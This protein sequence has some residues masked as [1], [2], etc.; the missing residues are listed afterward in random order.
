MFPICSTH[1]HIKKLTQAI[2]QP[3]IHKVIKK[4]WIHKVV[5]FVCFYSSFM[6]G[7]NAYLKKLVT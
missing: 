5:Q 4:I 6:V 2:L 7:F 1:T 3:K